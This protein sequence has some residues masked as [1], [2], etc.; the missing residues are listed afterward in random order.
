MKHIIDAKNR[1]LG[2][3]ASDAAK[4][5][6]GKDT[7]AFARNIAPDVEVEVINASKLKINEK[8]N[9]GKTYRTYSGHPGG[10]KEETLGDLTARKG[11]AE[12]VKR[13]VKG[14]LPDNKLKAKMIIK[15][16]VTE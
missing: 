9:K 1:T 4:F 14:M 5:L 16:K 12:A 6:M 8:K 10:Q 11:I 3:V 13:A 15:L 2:R 7:P